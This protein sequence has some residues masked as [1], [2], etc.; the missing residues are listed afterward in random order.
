MNKIQLLAKQCLSKQKP[1]K[2]L[3]QKIILN[4][5][6]AVPTFE[7]YSF[8]IHNTLKALSN[9]SLNPEKKYLAEFVWSQVTPEPK[10]LTD[11]LNANVRHIHYVD[12]AN[13]KCPYSPPI[14][15]SIM[16]GQQYMFYLIVKTVIET[17][18]GNYSQQE[19]SKFHHKSLNSRSRKGMQ[20]I[21]KQ[22]KNSFRPIS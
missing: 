13:S 3:L 12:S 20:P 7:A 8:V 21:S 6:K 15:Q 19:K 17:L 4:V 10:Q 18:K 1:Q 16:Q 9:K 2:N 11:W 14:L 22:I 5:A